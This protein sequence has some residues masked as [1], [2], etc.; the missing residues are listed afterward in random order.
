[1]KTHRVLFDITYEVRATGWALD[2]PSKVTSK[3]KGLLSA[4]RTFSKVFA[5]HEADRK[6]LLGR[7]K[8]KVS[9]KHHRQLQGGLRFVAIYSYERG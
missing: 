4:N 7:P 5:K 9:I 3:L 1:M 2:D 8:L 6:D